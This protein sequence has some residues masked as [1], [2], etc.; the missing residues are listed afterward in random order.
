[1]LGV[2]R[3]LIL[4][5]FSLARPSQATRTH[6]TRHDARERVLRIV[7]VAVSSESLAYCFE[8]NKRT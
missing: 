2:V 1:M 6:D 7:W 4:S 3:C 8:E 5:S